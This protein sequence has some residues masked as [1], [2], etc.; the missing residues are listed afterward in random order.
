MLRAVSR[1][2]QPRRLVAQALVNRWAWLADFAPGRYP[3][4]RDLV[5]AY[6]QP[7]NPAWYPE[8][9]L[10]RQYV[11]TLWAAG[12]GDKARTER[13]LARRRRD[14]FS[15]ATTFDRATTAAVF[16]SLHGPV[17]LP[18]GALEYGP[19]GAPGF[20]VLV[21]GRE[22][23]GLG[24]PGRNAI[25]ADPAGRGLGALYGFG[26]AGPSR[27]EGRILRT[28][29]PHGVIAALLLGALGAWSALRRSK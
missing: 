5:R 7:V 1:E 19:P 26:I 8:G 16:Q 28:T 17:V 25:Y 2:G 23:G 15:Q 12:E 10:H 14:E 6:A 4:L 24:R 9:E 27:V 3:H 20:R 18:P 29:A 11:A 13:E 22:Y 21:E